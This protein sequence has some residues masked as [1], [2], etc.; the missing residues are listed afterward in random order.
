MLIGIGRRQSSEALIDLLLECHERIRNFSTL[1]L[2]LGDPQ[3]ASHA[4]VAEGCERCEKY[5]GS[6]LPLHVKDEDESILPR[7]HGKRAEV[8]AALA[9]MHAEHGE[10]APQLAALLSALAALRAEPGSQSARGLLHAVAVPL[11]KA[12]AEHLELEER[13]IFPAMPELLSAETQRQIVLE[14]RARRQP[15]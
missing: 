11:T 15:G 5:F 10:H 8:D 7:M 14:L 1:L 12:F 13:V 4:E 9:K 3:G 2:K 6:A